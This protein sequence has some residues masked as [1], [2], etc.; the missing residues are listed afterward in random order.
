MVPVELLPDV[1]IGDV[2][3]LS[4][5]V[6]GGLACVGDVARPLFSHDVGV[7]DLEEVLRHLQDVVCCEP[8]AGS[9]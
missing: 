5:Q 2:E 4:A 1:P 3:Q 9:A 6:D 8:F 7:T